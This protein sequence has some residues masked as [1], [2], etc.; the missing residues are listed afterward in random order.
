M[1]SVEGISTC[2]SEGYDDDVTDNGCQPE[3]WE[4]NMRCCHY[5]ILNGLLCWKVARLIWCWFFSGRSTFHRMCHI[6]HVLSYCRKAFSISFDRLGKYSMDTLTV[7]NFSKP[8]PVNSSK[9]EPK[10]FDVLPNKAINK[11]L[12]RTWI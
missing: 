3:Y 12:G 1:V 9:G 8:I 2:R 6:Y 4:F 10:S 5:L 11:Q 7:D